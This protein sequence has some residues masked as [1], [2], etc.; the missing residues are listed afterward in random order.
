M[1]LTFLCEFSPPNSVVET[2]HTLF[3]LCVYLYACTYVPTC[4]RPYRIITLL[5]KLISCDIESNTHN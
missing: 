4:V 5:S 3:R 1:E 2:I